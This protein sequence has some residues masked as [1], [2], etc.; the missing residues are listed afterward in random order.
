MGLADGE[1]E[2]TPVHKVTLSGFYIDKYEV[3]LA[4]FRAFAERTKYETNHER[5]VRLATE[6]PKSHG[7]PSARTIWRTHVWKDADGRE[8]PHGENHPVV[9]VTQH[10]A[11]A[12]AQWAKKRLPT[13]AQWEYAARGATGRRYPW[14][15]EPMLPG[16][17]PA[18]N[19]GGESRDG[20]VF[21]APVGS[22][23]AAPSAFG[24]LDMGG[25]VAEWCSDWYGR[26]F[27]SAILARTKDTEGPRDGQTRVVRGGGW[28]SSEPRRATYRSFS[29]DPGASEP[30]V[31]FRCVRVAE[32][33]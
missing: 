3:R 4:Q 6:F 10:D 33:R 21:T 15:D 23:T 12:Y 32:G 30:G 27:Y 16:R 18:G 14:G 24:C 28:G 17:R 20:H 19:F 13:E 11:H 5:N 31:G 22:F 29:L 1:Y 2:E 25:N 7:M 26:G 9:H 8:I